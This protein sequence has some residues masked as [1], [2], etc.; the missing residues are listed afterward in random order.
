MR[1]GYLSL[2]ELEGETSR[3]LPNIHELL[4]V[5]IDNYFPFAHSGYSPELEELDD[6]VISAQ[7]SVIIP[8]VTT[9]PSNNV[10]S[11]K[12]NEQVTEMINDFYDLRSKGYNDMKRSIVLVIGDGDLIQSKIN[13]EDYAVEVLKVTPFVPLMMSE[14]FCG[15]DPSGYFYIGV[16][17]DIELRVLDRKMLDI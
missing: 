10:L 4:S 17:F 3:A 6:G 15:E 12:A 2:D 11:E 5:I 1:T 16:S 14:I 8:G 9:Y 13:P 7:L